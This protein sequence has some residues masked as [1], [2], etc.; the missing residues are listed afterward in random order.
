MAKKVLVIFASFIISVVIVFLLPST[1]KSF[2]GLGDINN[3][4][5]VEQRIIDYSE[6]KKM[7]YKIY[8]SGK[9]I[10]VV[11]NKEYL[12][13]LINSYEVNVDFEYDKR[14]IGLTENIY[15][16]EELSNLIYDDVDNEIFKYLTDNKCLGIE[17][18][19]VEFS[20]SEGIFERIYVLNEDDF[21]NAENQFILN[22]ISQESLNRI[23]QG[24]AIESPT[25][26]GSVETGISIKEKVT[27]TKGI[28]PLDEILSDEN[29]VYEFL[30]YG[31]NEERQYYTTKPG[32]TLAGVGYYFN[33]MSAKQIML[34]NPGIIKDEN[35]IIDAGTVLNVTYYSSP[36]TITVSKER[37]TQE[38]IFPDPLVYIEDSSLPIGQFQVDVPES[39][40]L[41]NVLYNEIWMNGVRQDKLATKVNEIIVK[42]PVRGR[43]L[44]GAGSVIPTET[45]GSGNWRWPVA[46]PSI[47][48]DYT[49]YAGHGGVDFYNLYNPWDYAHAVDSGVVTDT[50]WTDIGGYYARVD[51]G[52]GYST[53]YGHFSSP[54]TV[55]VGQSVSAGDILGPIG[56][57]G[58]AT[59]P[60]VHFAMYYD[61]ALINPC[62]VLDCQLLY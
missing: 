9:L 50:G 16:I 59:G 45:Y 12:F 36:L 25:T 17:T 62:S 5:L 44:I 42:D 49:C 6:S 22:F 14:A 60:H 4:S 57:T 21:K 52:N 55:I 53:Y 33:N 41:K 15:C 20:T 30:C 23:N 26:F 38:L 28:A 13:S 48:C 39:N 10:G 7:N 47:T 3:N 40:G 29:K 27:I 51:H 61:N 18:T 35:Q 2:D 34:L 32:D 43:T 54:A 19:C 8:D 11:N 56:M 1:T 31:R 37:L 24:E 58:N 46:N